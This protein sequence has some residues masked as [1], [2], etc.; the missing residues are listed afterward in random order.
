MT[1]KTFPVDPNSLNNGEISAETTTLDIGQ[2]NA[3]V[4]NTN[5]VKISP[6]FGDLVNLVD[7]S[8]RSIQSAS[9]AIVNAVFTKVDSGPNAPFAVSS[10]DLGDLSSERTH[11]SLARVLEKASKSIPPCLPGQE[12]SLKNDRDQI[13][14]LVRRI[15][16]LDEPLD[17]QVLESEAHIHDMDLAAN[18]LATV[19]LRSKPEEGITNDKS[20][21]DY[22]RTVF[23]SN[24]ITPKELD[25]F[26]K[27]C[28][29]AVQNFV[30]IMLIC[31]G[32]LGIVVE[33]TIGLEPGEQCGHCW[34]EGA[35]I[36]LTCGEAGGWKNN[37]NSSLDMVL[38]IRM[39][40]QHRYG[41]NHN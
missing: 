11:Q 15:G 6:R 33:T 27:L 19:I 5:I 1:A 10:K 9:S 37:A 30:L 39:V 41:M 20:D 28:W 25:S 32:V 17:E 31:L 18:A 3:I 8:L 22:R 24:A 38:V 12:E 21:I 4:D 40:I 34:F 36:L 16:T 2:G 26:F 23:G 13:E 14:A 29:Q 7:V 35:A